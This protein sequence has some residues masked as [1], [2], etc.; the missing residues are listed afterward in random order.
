[1]ADP[2]LRG[3][4]DFVDAVRRERGDQAIDVATV[5]GDRVADPEALDPP[6]LVGDEPTRQQLSYGRLGSY[7]RLGSDGRMGSRR[8]LG[9]RWL[10]SGRRRQ[11]VLHD[12]GLGRWCRWAGSS[13]LLNLGFDPPDHDDQEDSADDRESK[14]DLA[15]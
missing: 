15:D 1:V 4:D 12:G 9:H 7:D 8:L 14:R 6:Q 5:L 10:L 13:E 11:C 3:W 2:P